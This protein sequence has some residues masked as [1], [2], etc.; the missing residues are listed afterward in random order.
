M[1]NQEYLTGQEIDFFTPIKHPLSHFLFRIA[2]NGNFDRNLFATNVC[3]KIPCPKNT[4]TQT[5]HV[6]QGST[7]Y[8][9]VTNTIQWKIRKFAGDA[10]DV[11]NGEV[12]LKALLVDKPWQRPP[13]ALEFQ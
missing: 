12:H 5:M 9:P 2:L 3:V 7:K 4:S 13:I 11:L 6:G 8:D 10:R 1:V